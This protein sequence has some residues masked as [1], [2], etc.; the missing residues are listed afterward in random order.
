MTGL[1]LIILCPLLIVAH[2]RACNIAKIPLIQFS[3]VTTLLAF[4][5]NYTA[6]IRKYELMPFLPEPLYDSKLKRMCVLAV[7]GMIISMVW[8]WNGS[9]GILFAIVWE[10]L[11]GNRFESYGYFLLV[12]VAGCL[13]ME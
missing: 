2:I 5:I 6:I 8:G 9:G 7:G 4:L 12:V 3:F 10:S 11:R 1:V 13:V